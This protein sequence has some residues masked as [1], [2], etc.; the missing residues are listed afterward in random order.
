MR[1][2]VEATISREADALYAW[3]KVT[4]P[5]GPGLTAKSIRNRLAARFRQYKAAQK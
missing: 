4:H 2:E 5:F 1:G 3:L